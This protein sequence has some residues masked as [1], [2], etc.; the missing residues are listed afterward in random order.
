[1]N[2]DFEGPR[3]LNASDFENWNATQMKSLLGYYVEYHN[4]VQQ[5]AAQDA[6]E[7][8]SNLTLP[9]GWNAT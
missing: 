5:F 7:A 9:A 1:L 8:A 6:S 2:I 3:S 4:A